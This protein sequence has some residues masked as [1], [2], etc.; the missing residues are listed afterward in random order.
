MT[1]QLK[2]DRAQVYMATAVGLCLSCVVT[3]FGD[4]EVHHYST[5]PGPGHGHSTRQGHEG[6]CDVTL[7]CIFP[8]K[9][10]GRNPE[11][12][13]LLNLR[14]LLRCHSLLIHGQAGHVSRLHRNFHS[15]SN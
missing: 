5:L 9:N 13:P 6:A 2:G 1:T 8:S 4:P 12:Q 11:E 10:T 7:R 3:G 15:T 14:L